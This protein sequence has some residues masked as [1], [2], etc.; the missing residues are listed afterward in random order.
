MLIGAVGTYFTTNF[1]EEKV[2]FSLSAP[3]HF[4]DIIY[5][6]LRITNLGFN[7][8]TNVVLSINSPDIKTSNIQSSSQLNMTSTKDRLTGKIERIRRNESITVSFS[9]TGPELTP[10]AISI[11]S[12]RSIAS[13]S[14]EQ[15][16]SLDWTS[17]FIG[18]AFWLVI[19]LPMILIP[20]YRE[21]KRR[22][23]EAH[24]AMLK[25]TQSQQK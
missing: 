15:K 10:A 18:F 19:I 3:A 8:A 17:L 25:H 1:P 5:Q 14:E 22:A 2:V 12:D 16:W 23:F 4:G 9:Y 24:L 11:K 13:F 20:A 6:N 7:P 21:Y